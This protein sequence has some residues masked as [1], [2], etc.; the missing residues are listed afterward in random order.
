MKNRNLKP[1]RKVSDLIY[2]LKYEKGISFNYVTEKEAEFYLEN[3]NNYLRTASYRKNYEK[4]QNGAKAG[5]YMHL[6][7]AYLQELSVLDMHLRFMIIKMCLDIEHALK[8]SIVSH[9]EKN[10]ESD[11]YGIVDEFL[12][13]NP[14]II[15]NLQRKSNS[16]FTGDLIR[17]YFVI[18]SEGTSDS[19]RKISRIEA[20]DCPVWVL[21]ELLS[22]GDTIKFY[23]FYNNTYNIEGIPVN[24]INL[25]RNLRNGCAHNS[26]I[27]ANLRQGVSY[28]PMEIGKMVGKIP[29]LGKKQRAK[30]LS[31]RPLVEFV[32]MLY[33]YNEI[34]TER[35]KY[36]RLLEVKRLFEGRMR[37][38]A[39][40]FRKNELITSSYRFAYAVVNYICQ[41]NGC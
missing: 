37:E 15:E 8:V 14:Y 26:C 29:G 16:P 33:I 24:I 6:D 4:Y 34:V 30:K 12:K 38:K 40:Y 17:K 7:F 3:V 25:V 5:Q 10:L 31:C 21:L 20:T 11:G 32:S 18:N 35:V 39:F 22:F 9:S 23:T 2:K 41:L 13:N 28:P 1:Q 19:W 27:L 36:H